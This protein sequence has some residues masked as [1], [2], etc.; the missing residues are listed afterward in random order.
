MKKLF[1]SIQSNIGCYN[2]KCENKFCKS[3][4]N[5]NR[6]NNYNQEICDFLSP[7]VLN[8]SILTSILNFRKIIENIYEKEKNYDIDFN[9]LNKIFQDPEIISHLFL[10]NSFIINK[11]NFN[12]DLKFGY[13]FFLLIEKE[14]FFLNF[15]NNFIITF[16]NLMNFEN[17]I[18]KIII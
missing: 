3:S 10:E 1:D 4:K 14:P 7:L 18:M 17:N 15:K 9:I 6:N 16:N 2:V 12:I 13:F 11:F 5:F 8:P